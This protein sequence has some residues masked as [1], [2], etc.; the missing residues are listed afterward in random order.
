MLFLCR[1]ATIVEAIAFAI[2]FCGNITLYLVLREH[3]TIAEPYA[4]AIGGL[5]LALLLFKH[6]ALEKFNKTPKLAEKL[7]YEVLPKFYDK[8]TNGMN[9]IDNRIFAE[10]KPILYISKTGVKIVE[11]IENNIFNKTVTLV[12][13]IS[14][15]LSKQD[16][17]LQS[18]NVQTYNAYAFIIVTVIIA[19]VITGYYTIILN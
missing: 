14:K 9:F 4:A 12:G 17:I 11:W 7:F 6:N 3:Y 5:C 1:V 10:Y 19:L 13:K 18:G 16:M 15:A 8:F 2:L